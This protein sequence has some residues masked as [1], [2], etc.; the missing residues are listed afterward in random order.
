MGKRETRKGDGQGIPQATGHSVFLPYPVYVKLAINC[1]LGCPNLGLKASVAA[2]QEWQAG[3]T[4]FLI[5]RSFSF[6]TV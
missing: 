3:M 1:F 4:S 5:L 6:E 2:A